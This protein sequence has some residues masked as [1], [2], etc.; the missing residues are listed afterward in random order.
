V[1]AAK[2]FIE[3]IAKHQSILDD[4]EKG[5]ASNINDKVSLATFLLSAKTQSRLNKNQNFHGLVLEKKSDDNDEFLE[6]LLELQKNI[7]LFPSEARFEIAI[8]TS[9]I[10][11]HEKLILEA[12]EIKIPAEISHWTAVDVSIIDGQ[13]KT[14]VLDAAN[15]CGL[16]GIAFDIKKIFPHG[17]HYV[18]YADSI[19][20]PKYPGKEKARTIQSDEET[21]LT[22]TLEHLRQLTQ[23]NSAQ[24][25]SELKSV[26]HDSG[27][28]YPKNLIP[29]LSLSR[30]FRATQSW[31]VLSSLKDILES[32][33]IKAGKSILE[34]AEENSKITDDNKI[35]NTISHKKY[36]HLDK[37]SLLIE[38]HSDEIILMT[39]EHRKSLIFIKNPSLTY[40][41]NTIA[42]LP[43]EIFLNL[44]YKLNDNMTA[45]YFEPL[46]LEEKSLV[47]NF[48]SKINQLSDNKNLAAIK[49]EF[50]LRI[51]TLVNHLKYNNSNLS[52]IISLIICKITELT[53][54]D[55]SI[56]EFSKKIS[57][58]SENKD[59]TNSRKILLKQEIKSFKKEIKSQLIEL[60]D[61]PSKGTL[62]YKEFSIAYKAAKSKIKLIRKN[63]LHKIEASRM[64]ILEESSGSESNT[65]YNS[66]CSNLWNSQDR[67]RSVSNSSSLASSDF[68]ESISVP[69]LK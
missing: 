4:N 20:H 44:I 40:L 57:E 24:L 45:I 68:E 1:K 59:S 55:L 38:S 26:A 17:E 35:N 48:L 49:Q 63:E 25:Y 7:R 56:N 14:F 22:F 13:I 67:N 50:I 15:S 51:A 60:F 2:E 19:P 10:G 27:E 6:F 31:V 41:K 43:H 8:L 58:I 52:E 33:P 21:C 34:S 47:D 16:E 32:T 9:Y 42:S 36:K 37:S 28:I 5:S 11:N 3:S 64:T 39:L 53:K 65:N 23:I 61:D 12:A 46:E 54:I 69:I 66:N 29:G 62:E 18:F 30:I